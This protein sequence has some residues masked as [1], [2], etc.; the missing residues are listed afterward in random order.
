MG[1]QSPS[2][3][4]VQT[5]WKKVTGPLRAPSALQH[6]VSHFLFPGFETGSQVAQATLSSH[7]RMTLNS[8][9]SFLPFWESLGKLEKL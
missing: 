3:P 5:G 1:T 8:S 4:L 6:P 7:W 2:S 9:S